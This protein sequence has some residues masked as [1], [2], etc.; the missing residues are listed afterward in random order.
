M[1]S[2]K[3]ENE[4]HRPGRS[5]GRATKLDLVW[6]VG[7]K[8]GTKST[9]DF[10]YRLRLFSKGKLNGIKFLWEQ[11]A[12]PQSTFHVANPVQIR[13]AYQANRYPSL[14]AFNAKINP[15]P[16]SEWEHTTRSLIP[17]L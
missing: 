10:S 6:K 9:N 13:A 15:V 16:R 12:E 2:D 8:N 17:L 1:A 11:R 7:H 14:F 4:E 5:N 3:G